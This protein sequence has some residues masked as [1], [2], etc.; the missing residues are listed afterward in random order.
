[1]GEE[2]KIR[3]IMVRARNQNAQNVNQE[4]DGLKCEI[5][6]VHPEIVQN[7]EILA[8]DMALGLGELF[9]I[10][11]DPTRIR[12]MDVLARAECCVCDLAEILGM[13]Q[14]AVSHQLRLL[15][16]NHLVK[17]RRDGKMVYYTLD[18]E[19]VVQLYRQ[20]IEHVLE[21]RPEKK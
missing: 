2:K 9:R 5:D 16:N 14:S 19:H 20:G 10:L 11:G 7:L 6:Y 3:G 13:S 18:D 8:W 4:E 21:S 12:I 17:Y 15:R 1:M